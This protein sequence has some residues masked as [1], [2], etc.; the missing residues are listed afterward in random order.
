MMTVALIAFSVITTGFLTAG[1]SSA[2]FA[3]ITL[4]GVR[5][6]GYSAAIAAD[7]SGDLAAAIS[8][9]AHTSGLT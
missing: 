1:P 6:A 2:G 9:Q 8:G 5:E 4:D 7:P 3:T